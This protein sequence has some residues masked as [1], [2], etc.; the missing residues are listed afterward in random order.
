LLAIPLAGFLTYLL[1]TKKIKKIILAGIL[2][3]TIIFGIYH[4]LQYYYGAIHWDSMT[5]EAYKHS[6]GKVKGSQELPKY[7]SEPDYEKAKVSRDE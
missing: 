5:W 6:F 3:I 4:S 7:L 1:S 2:S